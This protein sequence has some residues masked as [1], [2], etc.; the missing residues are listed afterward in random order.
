MI[1]YTFKILNTHNKQKYINLFN[2]FNQYK[3][4]NILIHNE[5]SIVNKLLITHICIL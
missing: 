4:F 3:V 5:L 1:D 2:Q